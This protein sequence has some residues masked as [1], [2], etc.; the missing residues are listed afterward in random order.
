[1]LQ[2]FVNYSFQVLFPL[3]DKVRTLS[4]AASTEKVD[5]AG[6]ILIHH[7]RNTHR[8]QW[9]ETQVMVWAQMYLDEKI[10][11]KLLHQCMVNIHFKSVDNINLKEKNSLNIF[12]H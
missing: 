3:L 7:T 8:K 9:A 5:E 12:D 10:S 6:N 11:N 1:M 2:K 4:A